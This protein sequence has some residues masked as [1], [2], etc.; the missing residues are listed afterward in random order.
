M[1]VREGAIGAA[2]GERL[3]VS[4]LAAYDAGEDAEEAQTWSSQASTATSPSP[5]TRVLP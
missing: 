3:P 2:T 4:V 1:L 5:K